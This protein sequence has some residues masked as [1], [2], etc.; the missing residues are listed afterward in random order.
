MNRETPVSLAGLVDLHIHSAPDVRPRLLDDLEAAAQA[1]AAG[2]RAILLKSHVTCTADRAAIAEK[3][4]GGLRVVGSVALNYAVGGLNPV[5]VEVALKLGARVIWLPTISAREVDGRRGD[6]TI[7]EAGSEGKLS[8]AARA[9]IDLVAA[10]DVALGTGH[11]TIA[12]IVA[13]VKA[14]RAAGVRKVVV[15]HPDSRLIEM[16]LAVQQDLAAAGAYFERC[17]GNV[18]GETPN[19]ALAEMA[20]RIRT[21]GVRQTVLSTDFG[22]PNR[23]PPVE[24]M[25]AFLAALATEGF[26]ESDL[27][28]MAG[29]TPAMLLGI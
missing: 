29:E 19:V 1:R 17:Y 24:G 6:L 12:E 8:A 5:A 13:V 4:V 10:A 18:Y 3:A 21:A 25:R 9:V 20:H 16:P 14:A 11:L 15:T 2:M 22:Q 7:W 23:P 28:L 27:R 26:A